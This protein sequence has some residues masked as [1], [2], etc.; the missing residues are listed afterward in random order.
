MV[1][2]ADYA[3]LWNGM[4]MY[5]YLGMNM[6]Q[7][8]WTPGKAIALQHITNPTNM[9]NTCMWLTYTIC[10]AWATCTFHVSGTTQTHAI[11]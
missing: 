5:M 1:L 8:Y 11:P 7:G 9:E 6:L 2:I 4:Y 3:N 10:N